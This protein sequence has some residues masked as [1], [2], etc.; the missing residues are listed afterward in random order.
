MPIIVSPT[1][2]SNARVNIAYSNYITA[3][4]GTA[5]YTFTVSYG[6]LPAGLYLAAD[7]RL[8][9]TP[10]QSGIYYFT[11]TATDAIKSLG[12]RPYA[13]AVEENLDIYTVSSPN[14]T[15]Q[16]GKGCVTFR[17]KPDSI[18][19]DYIATITVNTNEKLLLRIN[20]LGFI[21]VPATTSTT[22]TTTR[23]QTTTSSTTVFVSTSTT[24]TTSTTSS[25]T[26]STTTSSP[27]GTYTGFEFCQ[28]FNLWRR[29]LDGR[30][31][32]FDLIYEF[33]SI[34][35]GFNV[36]TT[37]PPT[38]TSTTTTTTTTR[39]IEP[40]QPT[41]TSTTSTST[42]S[43]TSTSTT[44]TS[45]TSTTT[46]S[47]TTTSTSTTTTTT[48]LGPRPNQPNLVWDTSQENQSI[49]LWTRLIYKISDPYI[50]SGNIISGSLPIGLNLTK[51]ATLGNANVIS[52]APSPY[53]I[54]NL[55]PIKTYKFTISSNTAPSTVTVRSYS[56][57]V[58]DKILDYYFILP[59]RLTRSTYGFRYRFNSGLTEPSERNYWRLA[60]GLLP[61][62]LRLNDNGQI[63]LLYNEPISPF[64]RIRFIKNWIDSYEL[65]QD[66][67]EEWLLTFIQQPLQYDYQ[68]V[69]EYV[70]QDNI[71]LKAITVRLII[72]KPP[73]WE[74]WFY[75]NQYNLEVDPDRYY[76]L[77]LSTEQ[78]DIQWITESNLG[79]I[80]NGS[81][82][83]RSILATGN[84]GI[85]YQF[86]PYTYNRLP[87]GLKLTSRG[88]LTGRVSF[89]CYE[90]DPANLPEN[91]IYVFAVRASTNNRFTY[92]EKRFTLRVD[93]VYDVPS[94]NLYIYAAPKLEQRKRYLGIIEDQSMIPEE[95][96][97]RIN[98]PWFGL[99]K[100]MHFLFAPGVTKAT[101]SHYEQK[102]I[103]NHYNK[104]ILFGELKVAYSFNSRLQIDYEVVYLEIRDP[105]YNYDDPKL[106]RNTPKN[107]I[108]LR[109]YITNYYVKGG[110]SYYLLNPN[111]LQN[112]MS[113]IADSIGFTNIGLVPSWMTSIQPDNKTPGI[114]YRPVQMKMAMVI[115][116]VKPGMGDRVKYNLR[117]IN[118]NEFQFTFDRY[119]LEN[120]L[121]EN[122]D[123]TNRSFIKGSQASIFDNG[124]TKF[125]SDSTR[126]VE[127]ME[128]YRD[129]ETGDKYVKFPRA[130]V[131]R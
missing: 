61:P 123:Q 101:L 32:T 33:N 27:F 125:D 9:G 55:E 13:L 98:D 126:F 80:V 111:G 45:T 117:L 102:I 106:G 92:L 25:T 113:I 30:G 19:R 21:G 11:V 10:S 40:G 81:V 104:T 42:T 86:K 75:N 107:T 5:P 7:G 100:R 93:K 68:F 122:Y 56:I 49:I 2:L 65:S 74:D 51:D 47:T 87:Q 94:D 6:G 110:Q 84:R 103:T 115:A 114:F 83:D 119:Q 59:D 77:L 69:L 71:I 15:I 70:N 46:T 44:T 23:A 131:F 85:S 37:R 79:S 53:F 26:T 91:D 36:P 67:W 63:E 90:D 108:D 95:C 38:T 24:S 82:S 3:T 4:G 124:F 18:N 1:V 29:Y 48:T 41:T 116:Y 60:S 34:T 97:Y 73:V 20:N 43:T 88:Y 64:E 99:N 120:S 129:P 78:E 50:F 14:F 121:T 130:G 39:P 127:N 31:G 52:G 105:L 128:Y 96:I 72:T 62:H 8:G 22:T 112:M 16:N 57:S 89:R 54:T 58:V 109:P 17:V 35:C 28:G 118:W 76:Y 12:S 66:A